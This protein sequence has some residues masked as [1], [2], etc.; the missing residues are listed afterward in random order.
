MKRIIQ[1]FVID[2]KG[3]V[4][5]SCCRLP[6]RSIQLEDRR[7]YACFIRGCSNKLEVVHDLKKGE[8]TVGPA[9]SAWGAEEVCEQMLNLLSQAN[10]IPKTHLPVM[11]VVLEP[12]NACSN[13]VKVPRLKAPA[14]AGPSAS[15]N[16]PDSLE[17]S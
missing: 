4:S 12:P 17:K 11:T 3:R 5:C 10:Y 7:V 16:G 15:L 8:W 1:G 9:G 2:E 13:P 14:T 6:C